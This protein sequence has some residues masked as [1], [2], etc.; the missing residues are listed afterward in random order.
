MEY[1]ILSKENAR[2]TFEN[3]TDISWN[4]W[5]DILSL[6]DN[7]QYEYEDDYIENIIKRRH[8]V[9]PSFS[10]LQVV[11]GHITTSQ[12]ECA[13]IKKHGLLNLKD[14]C[15][16]PFS[17]LYQFLKAYGVTID[18]E[19]EVLSYKNTT[20]DIHY[21]KCPPIYAENEKL[22]WAVGRKIYYDFC[23]CGFLSYGQA[24]Y[25]GNVHCCPEI[26]RDI[27]RLLKTDLAQRWYTTHQTYE[28]VAITDASNIQ[29]EGNEYD[30]DFEKVMS[31]LMKAYW[32][33]FYEKENIV[34]L[35]NDA[36]I[37]TNN[38]LEIN[39]YDRW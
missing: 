18:V 15:S 32:R 21:G 2:R 31:Y 7:K 29:Y 12:E 37:S 36:I 9:L 28:I 30:S 16:N 17:E 20:Y 1:N 10:E 22:A 4:E 8:I 33:V 26:L 38:I 23:I 13:A 39:S 24:P 14:V 6:Y 3:I 27:D 34:L 19:R 35:N 11:F 25:G 5:M